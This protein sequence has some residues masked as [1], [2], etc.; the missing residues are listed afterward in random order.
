MAE[1]N[2]G[3]EKNS[4]QHDTSE[5][6]DSIEKPISGQY[7]FSIRSTISEAW[8]KTSG[9]KWPIQL[10]FFYYFLVMLAIIIVAVVA[11]VA[12]RSA[13]A[14]GDPSASFLIQFL[15]QVGI[16]IIGLPMLLGILIMGIQRSVNATINPTSV[17]LYFHKT[18]NLFLTVILMY[19]MIM[20]GFILLILPGIYL[21]VAY[22][23]ALPLVAEKDMS[24]WQALEISRKAIGHHWFRMVGF[25]IVSG[26]IIAI[27][28]IPFGIGLICTLP[29]SIIAYGILYRNMFGVENATIEAARLEQ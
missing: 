15:F 11:S 27:S 7:K 5:A 14:A 25:M 19:I 28:I 9:A 13:P 1:S 23:M 21:S 8:D 16:N 29:L 12:L 10:A 3:T 6:Y 24:P 2:T 26:I 20:I 4:S 17:F 18:F 22:Y